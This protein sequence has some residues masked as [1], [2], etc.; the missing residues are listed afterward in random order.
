MYK[1]SQRLAGSMFPSP[2]LFTNTEENKASL[3][4]DLKENQPKLIVVNEKVA[5]WSEVETLLKEH[6]QQV[7]TEYSEFK[8]YKIK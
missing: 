4:N 6:Y 7:K 8:V 3:I 1:E 2:L 5:L